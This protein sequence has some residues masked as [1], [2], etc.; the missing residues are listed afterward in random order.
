[1]IAE[2]ID[3]I[4]Y[5]NI[6]ISES[7][8]NNTNNFIKIF[9]SNSIFFLNSIY[10]KLK[11]NNLRVS[12]NKIIFDNL[13]NIEKIK[14]LESFILNNVNINKEPI[15]KLTNLFDNNI[16]KYGDEIHKYNILKISGIWETNENYG[17]TFK[18]IEYDDTIN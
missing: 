14:N 15:L 12:N 13:Y 17:I 2:D 18:I 9:Y 8:K 7:N 11:I 6:F 16:L 5:H 1:M 3:N 4:S 10:I